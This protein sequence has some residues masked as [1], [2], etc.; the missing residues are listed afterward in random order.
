MTYTVAGTYNIGGQVGGISTLAED[1]GAGHFRN[2]WSRQ[3]VQLFSSEPTQ[4]PVTLV[5]P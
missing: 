1:T 5:V 2:G 4:M 3:T